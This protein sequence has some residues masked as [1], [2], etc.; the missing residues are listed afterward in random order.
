MA[1]SIPC[2]RVERDDVAIER[3]FVPINA[4]L[5]PSQHPQ[6]NQHHRRNS[7]CALLPHARQATH[8]ISSRA[9]D[10][11]H[12]PNT[13]KVLIAVGD[14]SIPHIAVIDKA[15]HRRQRNRKKQRPG[16]RSTSKP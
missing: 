15:Q 1:V 11:D 8:A 5:T 13:S 7:P 2:L 16:Q 9:D 10:D 12:N 4:C 6:H 3:F 14:K